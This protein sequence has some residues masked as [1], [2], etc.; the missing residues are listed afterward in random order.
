MIF[1]AAAAIWF[2]IAGCRMGRVF[3]VGV[4]LLFTTLLI[5]NYGYRLFRCDTPRAQKLRV[6]QYTKWNS[7]SRIGMAAR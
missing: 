1:A 3:G 6:E 2:S 4:G 7:L 5:V